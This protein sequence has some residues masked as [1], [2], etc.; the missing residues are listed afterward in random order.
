MNTKFWGPPGWKFLH[1]IT[2]NYPEKIDPTNED[3]IQKKFYYKQLFENFQYTLPCKW[4]RSSYSKFL[5]EDPIEQNLETRKALTYWFYRIHN[6]VNAKLRK[7]ER[8][9][10]EKRCTELNRR[11][12]VLSPLQYFEEKRKIASECFFTPPDPT[13]GE[14]CQYYERQRASCS[15]SANKIASCRI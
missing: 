9:L 7:Q 14:V 4:C 11:A 2:F 6:K 3:H 8:E 5:S 15:K 12:N 10:F 1:T 13:Y